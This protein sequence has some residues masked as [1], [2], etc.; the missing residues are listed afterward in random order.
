M[1]FGETIAA[2]RSVRRFTDQDVTDEQVQRLLQAAVRAP[3]AG[4]LQPW[5]F[6]VVRD[7]D[8]RQELAGAAYGQGFVAEAPVVIAV[9][10][11]PSRSA[12]RYRRRGEELYCLQDTAAAAA[13]IL[14]AA[15][16]LGL[17]ACWV[18]AFDESA[19]ARALHLRPGQR[20]VILLPIGYP[21]DDDAPRTDRRPLTDVTTWLD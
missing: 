6:L 15:V 2:R 5:H 17:G 8:V 14:L 16:A 12:V 19:A 21:A 13:H 3:S 9:C 10:A 4:N 20:P 7:A 11:E 18:G 1:D